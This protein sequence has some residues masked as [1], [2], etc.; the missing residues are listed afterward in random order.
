V[1]VD[2]VHYIEE[3]LKKEGFK[4]FEV[5]L[6]GKGIGIL[7]NFD[8]GIIEEFKHGVGSVGRDDVTWLYWR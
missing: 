4:P 2:E 3:R 8:Q 7:E 5:E 6:G 1:D